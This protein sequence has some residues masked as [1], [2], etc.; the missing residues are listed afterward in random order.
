M[1]NL[2]WRKGAAGTIALCG[3]SGKVVPQDTSPTH[4]P[5]PSVGSGSHAYAAFRMARFECSGKTDGRRVGSGRK[6]RRAGKSQVSQARRGDEGVI[7][8]SARVFP[9]RTC[10]HPFF[11]RRHLR[12]PLLLSVSRLEAGGFGTLGRSGAGPALLQQAIGVYFRRRAYVSGRPKRFVQVPNRLERPQR[13]GS[14][15]QAPVG[16]S[17]VAVSSSSSS[18]RPP[19]SGSGS[20][21][22]MDKASVQV[23]TVNRLFGALLAVSWSECY[24]WN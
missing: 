7:V 14:S 9:G 3:W 10:T 19:G 22:G 20:G 18:A 16:P 15:S 5:R 23:L 4:I 13:R 12:R 1:A 8:R 17:K 6:E 24:S 21:S 2:E 11:S